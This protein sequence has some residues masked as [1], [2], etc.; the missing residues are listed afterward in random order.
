MTFLVPFCVLSACSTNRLHVTVEPT[1]G[2]KIMDLSNVPALAPPPGVVP[3]F[4]NPE[5]LAPLCLIVI[6]FTLPL[7]V[8]FL[9]LRLY[10]R[11]RISSA[12][13]ADDSQFIRPRLKDFAIACY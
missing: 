5:S 7:M 3:N 8:L 4:V 11:L 6:A 10:V 12:T 2:T 13:G 9:A 1:L